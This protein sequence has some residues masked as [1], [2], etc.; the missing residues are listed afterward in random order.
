MAAEQVA[1]REETMNS[2]TCLRSALENR[3]FGAAEG[4]NHEGICSKNE[5]YENHVIIGPVEGALGQW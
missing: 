3:R 5:D 4:Q 2:R 1:A